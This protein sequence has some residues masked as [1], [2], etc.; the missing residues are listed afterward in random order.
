MNVYLVHTNRKNA[1]GQ[2]IFL[3]FGC[4]IP[5]LQAFVEELNKGKAVCGSNLRTR[6]AQDEQGS[7]LEVV[8]KAP[9]AITA[10]GVTGV[11]NPKHRFVE[12]AE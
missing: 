9:Y 5:S 3:H 6:W 12:F 2:H 1:R 8:E 11:E 4:S 7:Y 10:A